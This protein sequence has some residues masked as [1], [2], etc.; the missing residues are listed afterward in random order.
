MLF[1]SGQRSKAAIES[2]NSLE[3]LERSLKR[4]LADS[5]PAVRES[6][7]LLFWDF[8]Q[9]WQERGHAIMETLDATA[10]KQL[11]KA[12]PNPNLTAVLP[13]TPKPNKKS[14]VAAAIAASRAKAKA[15]ATAPPTLRHQATSASH[16]ATPR[17]SG[18]PSTSPKNSTARDRK[19]VV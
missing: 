9:I 12:C 6:A 7:R 11:E 4:A 16:T 3:I 19:S 8:E 2:S 18:S 17:R 1:R 5:N 15:I 14:S 13:S 10:R